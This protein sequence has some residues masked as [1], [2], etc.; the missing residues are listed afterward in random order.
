MNIAWFGAAGP[1]PFD[2]T[3][4]LHAELAGRHRILRYDAQ[5]AHAFVW[6]QFR[7]P[8][9]ICVY[10]LHDR[11]EDA[12]VWPYLLHYPGILRLRS[13]DLGQSRRHTLRQSRRF[14]D[15][16]AEAA[17]AG[18]PR[19]RIPILASRL[20]IVGDRAAAEA[21]QDEYPDAR[22][23]WIAAGVDNVPGGAPAADAAHDASR[24][25][26]GVPS[27]DAVIDGAVRRARGSGTEVEPIRLD[28][29]ADVNR[30]D[31]IVALEWPPAPEPPLCALF[32][33]AAGKPAIVYDSPVTAGWPALD[34]RSWAPRG[35]GD[36]RPP[37]AISV[38]ARD[39]E[40]SLL[41]ALVRLGADLEWRRG[42]GAAAR[43]W[44]ATHATAAGAASAWD[45]ALHAAAA[46]PA[47][48]PP[49]GWPAHLRADG[50]ERARALLAEVGVEFPL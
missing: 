3:P 42:L 50:T 33:M 12:F 18:R 10:E 19:L 40:H 22:L 36:R 47:P 2:D 32:A 29:S 44:T 8:A 11:A 43:A 24:L 17:F 6:R 1:R 20:V 4:S 15:D 49:P 21:L 48:P 34:P 45:E 30:C 31:A 46:L 28:S 13:A 25:R 9:D 5:H 27:V 35:F 37:V 16:A 26:V 39:A 38:D 7:G 14:T 41:L 23:R